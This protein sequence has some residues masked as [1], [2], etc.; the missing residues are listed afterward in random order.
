VYLLSA[1]VLQAVTKMVQ[2]SFSYIDQIG[3]LDVKLKLIDTLRTV[4]AGKVSS[5]ALVLSTLCS[6]FCKMNEPCFLL[7][8]REH[9]MRKWSFE[10]WCGQE[11]HRYEYDVKY[12]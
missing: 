7:C 1:V 11:W 12:E 6:V 8:C 9:V 10:G 4:T 2:Q 3:D 5:R